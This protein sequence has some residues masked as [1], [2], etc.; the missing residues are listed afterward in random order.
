[1]PHGPPESIVASSTT[2]LQSSSS[3]LHVSNAGPLPPTH[4]RTPPTHC[5]VPNE[6]SPVSVPHAPPALMGL[7]SVTPSQSLS[8]PSHTS[9]DGPTAP[10]HTIMPFWHTSVPYEHSPTSVA[11]HAPP[12]STGVLSTSPS[13]LLS[14]PSQTSAEGTQGARRPVTL[15]NISSKSL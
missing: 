8:L 4:M 1:E 3:M 5:D 15:R 13:Q 10:M 9:T 12:A 2:P 11:P 14:A 6:H 7:S